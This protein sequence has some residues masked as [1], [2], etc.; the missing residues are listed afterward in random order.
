MVNSKGINCKI[1]PDR[2]FLSF[3]SSKKKRVI[4]MVVTNLSPK[5]AKKR[6]EMMRDLYAKYT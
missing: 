4:N 5:K 6:V 1:L 2:F 3:Y